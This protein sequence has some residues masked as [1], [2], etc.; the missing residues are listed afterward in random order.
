MALAR[1]QKSQKD[2]D[3]YRENDMKKILNNMSFKLFRNKGFDVLITHAPAFGVGDGKDIFHQGFECFHDLIRKY[4]PKYHF[5]GHQHL[6]Y[7]PL[8]ES[9]NNI[10][11]NTKHINA[12][13][14]HI[15][16]I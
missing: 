12:C 11:G 2:I 10:T 7:G 15:L 5:Y 16:D 13:G 14:Y 8:K 4:N 9:V 6:R 3:E 1:M